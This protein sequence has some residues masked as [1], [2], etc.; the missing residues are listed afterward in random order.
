MFITANQAQPIIFTILTILPLLLVNIALLT[1]TNN[2]TLLNIMFTE[3][4]SLLMFS[5]FSAQHLVFCPLS[6]FDCQTLT[7]FRSKQFTLIR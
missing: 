2:V 6:P 3:H 5:A 1:N 7:I 4:G